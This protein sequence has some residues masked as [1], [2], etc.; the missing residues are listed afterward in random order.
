MLSK[1]KLSIAKH[2]IIITSLKNDRHL[3]NGTSLEKLNGTGREPLFFS[4]KSI[5]EEGITDALNKCKEAVKA[6]F[7]KN[8]NADIKSVEIK[9]F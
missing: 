4:G 3:W 7:P 5:K 6:L 8:N 1:I 2:N 9:F